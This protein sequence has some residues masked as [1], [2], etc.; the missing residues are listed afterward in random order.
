[1]PLKLVNLY[2]PYHQSEN[3]R[4][5]RE[6]VVALRL[7]GW[8]VKSISSYLEVSRMTVYRVLDRWLSEGEEGLEDRPRGRPAGVRKVDLAT[9]ELVRRL[10]E[11]PELGEFRVHAELDECCGV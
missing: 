6:A 5:Q 3:G 4:E 10:Q 2:R 8:S 1:V 7:Y 9:I 11:N